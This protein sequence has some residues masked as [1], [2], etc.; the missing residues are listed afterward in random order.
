MWVGLVVGRALVGRAGSRGVGLA[1]G[2]GED[3]IL[4]EKLAE[5]FS[6][7]VSC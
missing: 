7:G 3:P 6:L 2:R 5:D 4:P 1:C